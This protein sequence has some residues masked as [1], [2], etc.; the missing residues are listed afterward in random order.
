MVT[1]G[2]KA[3]KLESETER[4]RK[5]KPKRARREYITKKLGGGNAQSRCLLNAELDESWLTLILP[6]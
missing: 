4:K 1:V 2:M 3:T 5:R 6:E